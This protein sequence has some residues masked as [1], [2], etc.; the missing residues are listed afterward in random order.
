MADTSPAQKAPEDV[1]STLKSDGT[2]RWIY[3]V[4]TVGKMYKRRRVVAWALMVVFVGLPLL[5]I[6]G[7]P[8][9][10][11]DVIGREFTLFGLTLYANDS[12]LFLLVLLSTLVSVFLVT[13]MFGRVWCGWACP[14]TVYLEFIFRPIEELFEGK[15]TV[16]KR[17]DEGDATLD[18][19][20]RKA[21]KWAVYTVIALGLAHTFVAY[22]V[23]WARLIDWM[24]GTPTD[25]LMFF[26]IMSVT[27]AL[28]LFDFGWF[29]EQMCTIACPYARIQ[30]V[31][32]DRDSMIVSYDPL[33]GETRGRRTAAQ[34]K[35]EKQG[36]KIVLGD[37]VDCFACVRTC[38]TGIDIRDGLQMECV[39]CT[40]CIDACD[41]IMIGVGKPTGL[42]RYTSENEIERKPQ[43]G[44]MRPR[45]IGYTVALVALLGSLLALLLLRTPFDVNLGRAGNTPFATLPDG[46][47]TNRIRIR[48]QNRTNAPAKYHIDAIEPTGATVRLVGRQELAVAAGAT[49]RIEAWV[50]VPRDRFTRGKV[51]AK[52]RVE[53]DQQRA[54]DTDYTLIG[55]Y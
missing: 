32:Q 55:P 12:L 26:G 17:R 8:A 39:G 48:I 53:D 43:R 1:L 41:A 47:V 36:I 50:V 14:Q 34:R 54:Q 37:C 45:T 11:L 21:G 4:R 3:P 30:S 5:K 18:R 33:R 27:T 13:A 19:F 42:I 10:L 51:P 49:E 25:H 22:F 7:K 38:P 24:H 28:I 15:P 44:L 35:E 6:N 52:F 9:V 31:L 23:G 40:Q 2:R 20:V 16:R 29:R 46:S